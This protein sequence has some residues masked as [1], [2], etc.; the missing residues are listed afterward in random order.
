MEYDRASRPWESRQRRR[1]QQALALGQVDIA[2][3]QIERI[4]RQPMPLLDGPNQIVQRTNL[5]VGQAGEWR[6]LD[7]NADADAVDVA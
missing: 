1:P 4:R 7:R 6:A 3:P 5:G 2:R